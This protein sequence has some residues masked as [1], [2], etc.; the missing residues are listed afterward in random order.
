MML[1]VSLSYMAFILLVRSFYTKF[2]EHFYH[3]RMLYFVKCFSASVE[4]IIFLSL[5][6]LMW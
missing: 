4:M 5:F 2:F 1:A 3:E 6:L